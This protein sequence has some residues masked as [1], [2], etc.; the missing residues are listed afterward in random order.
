MATFTTDTG[1]KKEEV[2]LHTAAVA[3]GVGDV[4]AQV[5]QLLLHTAAAALHGVGDE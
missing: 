4:S 5:L 2:Y 3:Q 1:S